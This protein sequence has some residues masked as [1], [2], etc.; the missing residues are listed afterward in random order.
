[1]EEAELAEA[2]NRPRRRL[3]RVTAVGEEAWAAAKPPQAATPP[4]RRGTVST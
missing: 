4:M 2:E 1:M 3:Y